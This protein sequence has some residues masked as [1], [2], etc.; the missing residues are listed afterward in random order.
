MRVISKRPGALV[1]LAMLAVPASGSLSAQ[2][3]APSDPN[4]I[5]TG[6]RA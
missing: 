4:I 3:Q 5:V 6:E 2:Q 1:L